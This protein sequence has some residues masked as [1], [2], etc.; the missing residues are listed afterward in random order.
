MTLKEWLNLSGGTLAR[1]R[2]CTGERSFR[3]AIIAFCRQL[4]HFFRI[5]PFG[6]GRWPAAP[7][8]TIE[9]LRRLI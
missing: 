7:V 6:E 3:L 1:D 2:M 9:G 5:D 4:V 8:R